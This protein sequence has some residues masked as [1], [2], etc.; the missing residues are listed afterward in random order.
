MQ[1][2]REDDLVGEILEKE[3]GK[4]EVI[5]IPAIE[6]GK[7]FWESRFS[8]EFLEE[9]RSTMGDYFF[10]SQYQQEPFVESGGDFRKDYFQ[11]Y[12]ELPK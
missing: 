9:M 3:P 4:W 7:S 12:E 6:N 2:W 5:K 8:V 10:Q 1:R 11:Y